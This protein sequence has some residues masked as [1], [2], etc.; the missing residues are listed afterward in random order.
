MGEPQAPIQTP[1]G[2]EMAA[3]TPFAIFLKIRSVTFLL[4]HACR[5]HMMSSISQE[6]MDPI[7]S[8]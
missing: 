7:E 1:I 5:F 4:F 2:E 8:F 3:F 6:D